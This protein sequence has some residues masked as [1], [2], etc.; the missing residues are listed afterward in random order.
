MEDE[1]GLFTVKGK[2][3]DGLEERLHD[4]RRKI[5]DVSSPPHHKLELLTYIFVSIDK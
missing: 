1:E 2:N 4:V 3:S 5:S